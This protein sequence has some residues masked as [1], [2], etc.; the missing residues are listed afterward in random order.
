MRKTIVLY[1]LLFFAPLL[2]Y[3]NF[4][5]IGLDDFDSFAFAFALDRWDTALIQ[6]QPRPAFRFM[7]SSPNLFQ[8]IVQ[9]TPLALIVVSAICGALS[10]VPNNPNPCHK[11]QQTSRTHRGIAPHF[12]A[13]I[14]AS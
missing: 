7:S 13:R 8:L 12:S 9:D 3:L 4:M 14:L 5:S 10:I 1:S 2:L 6:V 11:G